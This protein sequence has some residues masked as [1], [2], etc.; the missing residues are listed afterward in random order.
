MKVLLSTL[1]LFI[2]SLSP[3]MSAEVNTV[4]CP[5]KDSAERVL[6]EVMASRS[7]DINADNTSVMAEI[8]RGGC[9]LV[10][11]TGAEATNLVE[12][13]DQPHPSG[14][15][16]ARFGVMV[17]KDGRYAIAFDADFFGPK[18]DQMPTSSN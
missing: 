3:A 7:L 16:G 12:A 11:V 8:N 18:L 13:A 4:V 5:S 9:S 6:S 15:A 1:G 14:D 2:L 17:V 10:A